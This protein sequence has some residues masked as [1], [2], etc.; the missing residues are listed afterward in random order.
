MFSKLK[1]VSH[2]GAHVFTTASTRF[3]D[4][5]DIISGSSN[6]SNSLLWV[7]MDRSDD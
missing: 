4:N 6:S 3:H 1:R 5:C 2:P 7:R